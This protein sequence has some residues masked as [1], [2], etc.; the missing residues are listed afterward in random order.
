[1]N[2]SK[3]IHN[4]VVGNIVGA[5]HDSPLCVFQRNYYEHIIRNEEE[6]QHIRHYIKT[7]PQNWDDDRNNIKNIP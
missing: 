5:N 3:M 7:N 4:S 1:M 6:Y 2:S